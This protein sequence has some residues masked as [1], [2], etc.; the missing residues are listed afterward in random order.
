LSE[1][2]G[3]LLAAWYEGAPP[4]LWARLVEPAYRAVVAL[5]RYAYRRGWRAAGHPGR[6]VVV[7]GNLS[8]GGTGKTPLA[9]WLVRQLR[10]R[11]LQ[12][13]VVSRGYGGA[14]PRSP[15]AVS[16]E[17]EPGYAGDEPL[18]IARETGCP[19]WIC[20]DRLAAARAAVAAG[21]DVVIADDGL[22]HYRLRRDFEILVIDSERGFG[23]L[24]C[25]PAGPLREP[26]ARAD[27]VDFTVCTGRGG[28][29][30]PRGVRME[31]L[32]GDAVR[33]DG[34]ERRPLAAFAG[35]PVHAIAGIGHPERFFRFLE[36]HGLEL[37]RH[38]LPDHGE[39]PDALL[40]PADGRPVLMTSKDLVRCLPRGRRVGAWH[41]PVAARLDA[42]GAA[43]LERL[44]QRLGLGEA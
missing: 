17:D 20:R 12:P 14:Q 25:L 23:N 39:I 36:L 11:G 10:Q 4:P 9:I 5:R 29:C 30:P 32:G 8:V 21:A 44:A 37:I 18:L 6:P 43:L 13:A 16:P 15:H 31:L 40:Q 19:V 38:P 1:V 34:D 26:P 35:Q 2:S 27:E 22:Q 33:A 41:V 24:R 7:I 3:R 28:H 42:D